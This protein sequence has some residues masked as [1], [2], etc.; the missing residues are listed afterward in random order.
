MDLFAFF[1]TVVVAVLGVGGAQQRRTQG[2][3]L[4][5]EP[6]SH[7]LTDLQMFLSFLCEPNKI[8]RLNGIEQILIRTTKTFT[9]SHHTDCNQD[10]AAAITDTEIQM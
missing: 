2:P 8:V 9:H 3:I 5:L 4:L 7:L 1:V 6:P 10:A